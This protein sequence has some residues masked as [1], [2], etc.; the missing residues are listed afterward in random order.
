MRILCCALMGSC[1]RSDMIFNGLNILLQHPSEAN[2]PSCTDACLC[3]PA[4][5]AGIAVCC[6]ASCFVN[7]GQKGAVKKKKKKTTRNIWELLLKKTPK[8]LISVFVR[9]IYSKPAIK[10][11]AERCSGFTDI[12][13]VGFLKVRNAPNNCVSWQTTTART[14]TSLETF[15]VE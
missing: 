7:W 9:Y 6:N 8:W 15:A 5:C 3:S 13:F 12:L 1:S 10:T 14:R 2:H 4:R 11:I